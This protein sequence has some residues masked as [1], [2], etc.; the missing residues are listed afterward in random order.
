MVTADP[1][2]QRVDA[3]LGQVV[4]GPVG[5]G[6]KSERSAVWIETAQGRYLLRRQG[7]PSH[8][9]ATLDRHVGQRV[10]CSGFIVGSSLLAERID[11]VDPNG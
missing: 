3:L 11:V 6:S 10:L 9:D 2:P 8:G 4:A 5:A 1:R 7:G